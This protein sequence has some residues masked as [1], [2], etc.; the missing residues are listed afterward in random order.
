MSKYNNSNKLCINN[1]F[2]FLLFLL[3]I[4]MKA[5]Y[6]F[7]LKKYYKDKKESPDQNNSQNISYHS[8]NKLNLKNKEP[9]KYYKV[10]FRPL[11][12]LT[13]VST[14]LS[15]FWLTYSEPV[16][17]LRLDDFDLNSALIGV[18]FSIAP[19]MYT[20]SSLTI[21]WVA[22]KI[23]GRYIILV[24]LLTNGL[25]Q[26]LIG[27]SPYLPNSLAI[28]WVGQF[29]HGFTACL[30]L[31]TNLPV[32]INDTLEKYPGRKIDASDTSSAIFNSMQA[33]GNMIG[34][35]FGSN[36]TNAYSFRICAD[37]VG[38]IILAYFFIY[39]IFV[40]IQKWSSRKS[41]SNIDIVYNQQDKLL[42]EYW[43]RLFK[44][45]HEP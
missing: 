4:L 13:S 34:P 21:S 25:S 5:L 1:K 6:L 24:G 9:I 33:I 39:L 17:S 18:F 36:V 37:V 26:F 40:I 23:D 12:F 43:I 31:I 27:P 32:M 22:T 7:I 3:K 38:C 14:F 29:L 41:N 2:S 11:F 44:N 35:I 8:K 10:F 30:Y 16:L 15:L 42:S 28:M 20:I 19:L 45:K